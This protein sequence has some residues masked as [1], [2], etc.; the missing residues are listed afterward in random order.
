MMK[1]GFDEN[2]D[3]QCSSACRSLL[4]A[5]V[6]AAFSS[7]CAAQSTG[8]QLPPL[9]GD[10]EAVTRLE[11]MF[12]K[13]GGRSTWAAARGIYVKY[14]Q[15]RSDPLPAVGE[16]HAWRDIGAPSER[17][18]WKFAPDGGTETFSARSF[19]REKG[20]RL[21][22]EGR[23]EMTPDELNRFHGLWSR[24]FYTMFRRIG[25]GDPAL[26]YRFI[27]PHRIEVFASDTLQGWWTIDAGGN[28]LQWGTT[29]TTGQALSYSYGPIK[30]YGRIGFP[31]WG[32]SNDGMFRFEYVEIEL[33]SKPLPASIFERPYEPL[34]LSGGDALLAPE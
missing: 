31:A 14:R 9:Q 11:R 1:T 16:E 6:L 24:D 28:I 34:R 12:T 3:M 30:T 18:E 32:V 5:L 22:A 21:N 7:L 4:L 13:L 2:L 17:L 10:A 23:R 33:G 25:A 8:H 20:W 27:A 19:T 15:Y 29:G 26:H